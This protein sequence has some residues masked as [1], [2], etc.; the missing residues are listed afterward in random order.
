MMNQDDKARFAKPS[1]FK[2]CTA[3]NSLAATYRGWDR[4]KEIKEKA[5]PGHNHDL[6]CLE[7]DWP[8]QLKSRVSTQLRTKRASSSVLEVYEVRS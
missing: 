6:V 1:T 5:S 7:P 4:E 2:R 3:P 8:M